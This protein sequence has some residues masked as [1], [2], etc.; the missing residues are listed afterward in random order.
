MYG[1]CGL[2]LGSGFSKVSQLCSNNKQ[3]RFWR[4]LSVCTT[5][6]I[7]PYYLLGV[8]QTLYKS[9]VFSST[10]YNG[11]RAARPDLHHR[12][13]NMSRKS[14]SMTRQAFEE[15]SRYLLG[16]AGKE[17]AQDNFVFGIAISKA[18]FAPSLFVHPTISAALS[19]GL[20]TA[21]I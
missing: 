17:D 7:L 20:M 21:C 9:G 2:V 18:P 13:R 14:L 6:M 19:L 16:S 3:P 15:E 4:A 12:V 8:L 5:V 10:E 11:L 1:A